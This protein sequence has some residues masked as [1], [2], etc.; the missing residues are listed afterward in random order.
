[1]DQTLRCDVTTPGS[2]AEDST[3]SKKEIAGEA[4]KHAQRVHG[5]RIVSVNVGRPQ[6][7]EYRGRMIQTG[8]FKKPVSGPVRIG[9][10]NLEGDEQADL[11]LHGGP[12]KAVYIYPAAHYA[13]WSEELR[14]PL[15]YG[16]FGE[17]LT[18]EGVLESSV[19]VGDVFQAGTALLQVT[20]PRF[21]CYKLGIRMGDLRFI[22][23]FL[24]SGRTGFYTRVLRE[25]QVATG[26]ALTLV[27][28]DPGEPTIAEVVSALT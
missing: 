6:E 14:R 1:M 21:P 16:Q 12:D 8:I 4:G 24:F 15:P 9:H 23:R 20:Q 19:R 25:G 10:L 17:N 22:R 7:T 26:N 13:L 3:D 2:R 11:R 18:V 28:S 27:R 5:H